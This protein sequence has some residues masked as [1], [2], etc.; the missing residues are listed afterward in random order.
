MNAEEWEIDTVL[1]WASYLTAKNITKREFDLAKNLSIDLNFPPNNAKEFLD[2]VRKQ[3]FIDVRKAYIEACHETYSH[4]VVYETASRVGF[5]DLKTRSEQTTWGVW[6]KV[7]QEVCHEY[8]AGNHFSLPPS[9]QIAYQE[10]K[11][12]SVEFVIELLQK[13]KKEMGLNG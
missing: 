4:A 1:L 7:Y 2:L 3:M 8:L 5:W 10:P 12:A 6:Q 11:P 13:T 9:Q